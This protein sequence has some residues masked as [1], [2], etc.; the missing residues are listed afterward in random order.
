M[1]RLFKFFLPI[2]S[3]GG[4][5]LTAAPDYKPDA[6]LQAYVWEYP[7]N[8]FTE[9]D[10][11]AG[12]ETS[13]RVYEK[14]ASR[15]LGPG[16]RKKAGI[17]IYTAS[18]PGLA[19]P[20]NLVKAVI[21]ALVERG[22][23]K[24]DIFI[25]DYDESRMR[26]AGYLPRESVADRTFEG[27]PV[28]ALDSGDYFNENWFY[29]SNLPSR[30][31]LAQAIAN[32]NMQFDSDP[33]DR[34]SFLNTPLLLDVEFWINLP[35]VADSDAL[36]VS[37]ALGNATL[38]NVSNN[39]RFFASPANAP[40]AAAEIGGIPE[41]RDTWVFNIITLE[42]YQYMGGPRYNA[43]YTAQEKKLWMSAN[44]VALDYLMWKRIKRLKESQQFPVSE[45]DP[46]LFEYA[47]AVGLGPYD[48]NDL[49]L[50][51]LAPASQ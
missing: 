13:F 14:H 30:E 37:G 31:R 50:R 41:L 18:G 19:T 34:K 24:S 45:Q 9:A 4:T 33:N 20:K 10:Y 48:M 46:P 17:K 40:V 22:F 44:P 25:I 36:G 39:Q 21:E 47:K 42:N 8:G 38:W 6:D 12:V 32:Y 3:L 16:E 29:D 11:Y 43:M 51:R 7:L 35:M 15:K 26:K 23:A 28:I 2:L 1:H 5:L 27:V 49:K